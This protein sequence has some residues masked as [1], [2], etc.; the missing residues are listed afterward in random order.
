MRNLR[1]IASWYLSK[2]ILV[3]YLSFW[4]RVLLR[5]RKPLIVGITGSVGKTT[6]TD[7]VAAT[8]MHA[9]ALPIVGRVWKTTEN[10]NNNIGLPLTVLGY[11]GWPKSN[12]EWMAIL[13]CLPFRT[14]ALARSENYPEILVLEYAAGPKGDVPRLVKIA[15]PTLAVVTA[16]GPAH[17]ER[18][19]TV[20][21]LVQ[22]KSALVQAVP[23]SGLVILGQD[24][25][26]SCNM[27]LGTQAQVVKV[28]GSGRKL[29]ENVARTVARYFG[30][31]TEMISRALNECEAAARRLQCLQ[32]GSLTVIDDTFNANPLSMKLGLDMLA[33]TAKTQ[34]RRVAILGMM[35]EL[36]TESPRYHEEI[37]DYARKRADIVIGV[38]SLASHYRPDYWFAN[39]ED[40]A[41]SLDDLIHR[42]DCLF[43]KGSHSVQLDTVVGRLKLLFAEAPANG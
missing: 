42:G 34:Q 4:A 29:S 12:R 11:R 26:Y 15:P 27:G 19:K 18:F 32:L 2:F 5:K 16:V 25:P 13:C 39:S 21:R 3:S 28:N 17:L 22:E 36:G 8:L 14:F 20:E 40:C 41:K 37:A 33:E 9:D 10:M 38:G 43:V 31:S 6:T 1:K 23:P 30:L 7:I 24:N 35:G